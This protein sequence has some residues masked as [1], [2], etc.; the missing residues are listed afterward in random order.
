MLGRELVTRSGRIVLYRCTRRDARGEVVGRSF[1]QWCS[2]A[3]HDVPT[4][5]Q[6]CG[7]ADPLHEQNDRIGAG[8]AIPGDLLVFRRDRP[9]YNKNS[10]VALN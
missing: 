9:S 6:L 10:G 4:P 3:H 2:G 1:L 7:A 5:T 8:H